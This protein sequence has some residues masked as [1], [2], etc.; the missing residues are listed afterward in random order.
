MYSLVLIVML[1]YRK[2]YNCIVKVLAPIFLFSQFS[3]ISFS[4]TP[5]I[6]QSAKIP[7]FFVN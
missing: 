1:D 6:R 4:E 3:D 7:A 2:T 5:A